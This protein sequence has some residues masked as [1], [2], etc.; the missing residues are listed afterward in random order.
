MKN[1]YS[2]EQNIDL[3]INSATDDKILYLLHLDSFNLKNLG[4]IS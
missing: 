2:S 4:V 1:P 3:K